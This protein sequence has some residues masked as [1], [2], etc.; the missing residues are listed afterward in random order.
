VVV[1]DRV[2]Y[3]AGA[4]VLYLH[5]GNPEAALD[6]DGSREGHALRYDVDDRLIGMTILNARLGPDQLRSALASQAA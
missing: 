2:S 1:A 6:F 3:D 4:D 5:S